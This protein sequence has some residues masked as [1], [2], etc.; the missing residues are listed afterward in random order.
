[1]CGSEST[2]PHL[3][4]DTRG[5]CCAMTGRDGKAGDDRR[6]PERGRRGSASDERPDRQSLPC[7]EVARSERAGY[8]GALSP[9]GA[10]PSDFGV[11]TGLP[12]VQLTCTQPPRIEVFSQYD[13][14]E[15]IGLLR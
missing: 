4:T 10:A 6:R 15:L 8:W 7:P 1:M 14:P 2:T 11:S 13:L 12:V 3:S 9:L 5:E